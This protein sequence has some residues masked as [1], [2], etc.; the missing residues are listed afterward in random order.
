[1]EIRKYLEYTSDLV[2]LAEKAGYSI[3]D[4]LKL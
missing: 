3:P 4:T 2:N 1:M